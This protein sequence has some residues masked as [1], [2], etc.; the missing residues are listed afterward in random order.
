M[1]E[2]NN[3]NDVKRVIKNENVKVFGIGGTPIT[4]T[5]AHHFVD[6]FEV[7]C[8]VENKL[9]I[10]QISE[11]VK[12]KCFPLKDENG[13][14][15]KKP[16]KILENKDVQ[17]YISIAR[18]KY[19]KIAIF[20]LKPD[21]LLEKICQNNNWIL[22]GNSSNI[23]KKYNDK[24]VFQ[25]ILNETDLKTGTFIIQLDLLESNL[26]YIFDKFGEKI[27]IQ[28]PEVSGGGHGTF[29]FERKDK[30]IIIQQIN[31]RINIISEK[32]SPSTNIIINSFFSGPALSI[33]GSIT[34]NNEIIVV[35]PQHQLIDIKEVTKSKNDASGIFCGHDW[36]LNIPEKIKK[37]AINISEKIG[38]YLKKQ[39]VVGIFGTDLMWDLKSNQV[40]PI[41]INTRLTGV[42]PS[43]VDVQLINNEV[44]IL[45]FHILDF[46]KISYKVSESFVY[47][48]NNFL[49]GAQLIIFNNQPYSIRIKKTG[50]KSGIY[51]L[52][53]DKLFFER[54]GFEMSDIQNDQEFVVVDNVP[55]IGSVYEKNRKLL[56]IIS[57]EPLGKNSY[58]LNEWG[59]EIV[60][61][62]YAS[63]ESEKI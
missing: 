15:I 54:D 1:I 35:N 62:V 34:Q 25:E 21:K 23:I 47:R 60:E 58:K 18:K 22:I 50:I 43:F 44:P 57:K 10:S 30:D 19:D 27:V 40:V 59:R 2:I 48:K 53:K 37:Q 12:I 11:K 52:K 55:E 9:E 4:R 6:D 49:T 33:L 41:E 38:V 63:I 32:I 16:S 26:D 13:I 56:R 31:N 39:G 46:L 24:E 8:S 7:I 42:F 14:Y 17:D 36:T 45:A 29:F 3:I 28:F 51:S 5:E 20:V 61:K